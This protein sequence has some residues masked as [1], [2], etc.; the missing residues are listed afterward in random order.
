MQRGLEEGLSPVVSQAFK[1]PV[2][3][4][5][6]ATAS[7]S[8]RGIKISN[9]SGAKVISSVA[10]DRYNLGLL[11]IIKIFFLAGILGGIIGEIAPPLKPLISVALFG[12]QLFLLWKIVQQNVAAT[13]VFLDV[14]RMYIGKKS[15][16]IPP[17][18]YFQSIAQPYSPNLFKIYAIQPNGVVYFA[19]NLTW[20]E[21]DELIRIAINSLHMIQESRSLFSIKAQ[22][23]LIFIK[24]G[25][26]S[27]SFVVRDR[28]RLWQSLRC[29]MVDRDSVELTKSELKE[30]YEQKL[31]AFH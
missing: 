4:L 3:F 23:G 31:Q 7:R 24:S 9:R 14:D 28:D 17:G 25:K 30:L 11:N 13:T 26:T 12:L 15:Y 8:D 16:P 22:D 29:R 6:R 18:T 10:G 27:M 5:L 1:S 2:G 19:H 21:T 20:H